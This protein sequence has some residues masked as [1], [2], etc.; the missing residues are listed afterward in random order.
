MQSQYADLTAISHRRQSVFKH[1]D[2]K[3]LYTS[4]NQGT[5]AKLLPITHLCGDD[6]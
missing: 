1:Y 4:K 3:E 5:K 6:T 2:V